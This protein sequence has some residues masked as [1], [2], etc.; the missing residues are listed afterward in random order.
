MDFMPLR[1][2]SNDT[3]QT[4]DNDNQKV[5]ERY[6]NKRRN[7]S[8][9]YH[10]TNNGVHTTNSNHY[11]PQSNT[12]NN[13]YSE[14]IIFQTDGTN[15]QL[16]PEDD[17]SHLNYR[18]R[19]NPLPPRL[20][21]AQEERTRRNTNRYYDESIILSGG[22][23]NGTYRN[24]TANNHSL[25]SSSSFS[26][27]PDQSTYISNGQQHQATLNFV[28]HANMLAAVNGSTQPHLAYFQTNAGPL[29]YN[30]SGIPNPSFHN[31]PPSLAS[32]YCYG[33]PYASP[34]YLPATVSNGI[35]EDSKLFNNQSGTQTKL[36]IDENENQTTT[37]TTTTIGESQQTDNTT[38]NDT[39]NQS[40][41]LANEQKVVSS[42]SSSNDGN[43]TSQ[44]DTTEQNEEKRRDTHPNPRPR[45]RVNDVCFARWSEDREFYVATIV[46]IQP[47]Y[48]TVV[49]RDYN[50][51]DQVHFGDLKIL[52]R[53]QQYYPTAQPLIGPSSNLNPLAANVYFPPRTD[54]YPSTM[55]GCI[56][57]PEAP[58]FPFNSSGTL[59]MCPPMISSISRSNRYHPQDNS[60]FQPSNRR[61]EN[62][63]TDTNTTINS[64]SSPS[65]DSND[66]SIIDS[67]TTSVDDNQ[68]QD[69][70]STTDQIRLCSIADVPLTL[71]TKDEDRERSTSTESLTSSRYDEQQSIN[72]EEKPDRNSIVNN[73][74]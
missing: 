35:D 27:R 46:Q 63:I 21:R 64:S 32:S 33:P 16:D 51:Y 60:S 11:Y 15:E 1:K 14:Q 13:Y 57:M 19:R 67:T 30:M 6:E 26:R 24:G 50:T 74:S 37:T 44:Q 29:T 42:S 22:E 10:K 47:P 23:L 36:L 61:H 72:E 12:N 5:K 48:C 38:T 69:L 56:M 49:F 43:N 62:G 7:P 40:Q 41:A 18:E 70:P 45:W 8:E 55:D 39:E 2:N 31:Q 34:T 59:Y 53:D 20:Q 66:T 28:P 71:V 25:S 54:Y 3:K 65:K 52:P 68:Q 58:P 17:P 9:Q 73:D 4:I